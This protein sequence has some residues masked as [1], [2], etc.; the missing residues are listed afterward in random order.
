VSEQEIKIQEPSDQ[1]PVGHVP[2]SVTLIAKG[3]NTKQCTP[4]DI[5]TVTGVHLPTPFTGF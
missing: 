3:I 2:R 4:G 1:V 5:I